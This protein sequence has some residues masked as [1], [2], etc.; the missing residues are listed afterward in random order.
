MTYSVVIRTGNESGCVATI[1][2]LPGCG[3]QGRTRREALR[4][5]KEVIPA[6]RK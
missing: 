5:A 1:P 2:A 4:N 3:S 6:L